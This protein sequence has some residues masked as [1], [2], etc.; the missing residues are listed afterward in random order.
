MAKDGT[1]HELEARAVHLSKGLAPVP[2]LPIVCLQPRIRVLL[3]RGNVALSACSNAWPA[4]GKAAEGRVARA[5]R[6]VYPRSLWPHIGAT[7]DPE[8]SS[9][10]KSLFGTPDSRRRGAER[11][12]MVVEVA[13]TQPKNWGKRDNG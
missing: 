10:I 2:L 11:I 9:G 4:I 13:C 12:P 3:P 5:S 7:V 6:D 8:E 1:H